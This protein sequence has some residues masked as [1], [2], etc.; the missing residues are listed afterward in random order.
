VRGRSTSNL[1]DVEPVQRTPER[2]LAVQ[3][4]LHHGLEDRP[5]PQRVAVGDQMQGGP[6]QPH[7]HRAPFGDRLGQCLGTEAIQPRPQRDVGIAR[8]LR[9][10]A[11]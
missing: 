3:R 1:V 6:Q 8:N 2:A 11:D 7:P 9:L 10:E 5:Q 4:A